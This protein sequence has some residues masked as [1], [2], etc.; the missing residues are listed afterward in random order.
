MAVIDTSGSVTSDLLSQIDG[1]LRRLAKHYEVLVVECDCQ[2][3]RTYP[4]QTLTTVWG[5]G[6]TDLRP[7]LEK[8]FL[9]QHKPDLVVYFTDGYGP[10]HQCQP[11]VPVIWCLTPNGTEPVKWGKK[12][13]M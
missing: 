11:A 5:R 8:D 10:A 3:Q 1:E 2:I 12:I 9:R 7:P 13:M 4:Y 6:G